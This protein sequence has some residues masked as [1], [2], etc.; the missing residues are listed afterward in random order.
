MQDERL[1]LLRTN[2]FYALALKIHSR[3]RIQS[4]FVVDNGATIPMTPPKT[5]ESNAEK[6]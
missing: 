2:K 4:L 1:L 6:V 3:Y 5:V